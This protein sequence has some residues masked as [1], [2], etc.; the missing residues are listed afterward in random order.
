MGFYKE[1]TD[2]NKTALSDLQSAWSVLRDAVVNDF[3]FPNSDT[4]L[5]YIDEAMSLEFVKNLKLMKELLLFIC[6]IASQSAPE[7]IIK[8]SEMVRE[9]LEDVFSAI[10]EGGKLCQR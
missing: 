6:N 4:L 1:P 10:A 9:A 8:L 5:F 2:Y 3:S 7:E